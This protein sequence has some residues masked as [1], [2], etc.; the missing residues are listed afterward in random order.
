[1]RTALGNRA[2]IVVRPEFKEALTKCFADILACGPP[3]TLGPSGSSNSIIAFRFP[4]GGSVRFE[5][6]TDALHER[7]LRRGAWLKVR[8]DDLDALRQR[9]V[10]AGLEQVSTQQLPRFT[11]SFPAVRSSASPGSTTE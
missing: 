8:A 5:F 6:S 9:I 7:E 10:D 11:S 1:M 2:H 4:G 3:L